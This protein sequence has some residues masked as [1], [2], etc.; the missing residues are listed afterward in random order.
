[1][2]K[3]DKLYRKWHE[4]WHNWHLVKMYYYGS[5]RHEKAMN[6][7]FKKLDK[8]NEKQIESPPQEANVEGDP[9]VENSNEHDHEKMDLRHL[10]MGESN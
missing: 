3:K 7:H 4:F 2:S 8:L 10:K 9:I 6:K 1:M 5:Y